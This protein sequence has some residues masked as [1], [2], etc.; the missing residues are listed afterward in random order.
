MKAKG[1]KLDVHKLV[2]IPVDLRKL[3]DA[4]KNYVV[5]KDV[6]NAKTKNIKDK[7]SDI[8][9]IAT[10]ASLN[11]KMNKAKDEILSSNNLAT[12]AVLTNVENK[13]PNVNDLAKKKQIMMEKYQKWKTNVLVLLNIISSPIIYLIQR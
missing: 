6:Y 12:I 4:V 13:I 10:N 1:D 5:K 9:N 3:S 7:I 2:L 11:A 8:F